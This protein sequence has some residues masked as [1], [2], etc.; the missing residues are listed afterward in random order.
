M[1][2]ESTS[3]AHNGATA[4]KLFDEAYEAACAG[5]FALS[6]SVLT[7]IVNGQNAAIAGALLQALLQAQSDSPEGHTILHQ[8]AWHGDCEAIRS[9]MRV[10]ADAGLP[11]GLGETA[12]DVARQR[13]HE[14]AAA[15]LRV[16]VDAWGGWGVEELTVLACLCKIAP[17]RLS[18]PRAMHAR[19][20][21]TGSRPALYLL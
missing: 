10:G 6:L 15:L 20:S 8:A 14:E 2:S 5:D 1:R 11:N 9:L 7:G 21:E 18:T 16:W 13:G 12:L 4:S 17:V 19:A 3:V